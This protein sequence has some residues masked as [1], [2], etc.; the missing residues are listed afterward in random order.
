M[1][2]ILCT[3]SLALAFA[4][5]VLNQSAAAQTA[6]SRPHT[7]AA[8]APAAT[9]PAT[10][11]V[12][13]PAATPAPC[14]CMT[15]NAQRHLPPYTAKQET[16]HV[17]TLADGTNV[18]TVTEAEIWR[19]ADGRTRTDTIRT[20]PDGTITRYVSVYDPV[21]RVRYS[22]SVG[23]PS[24]SKIVSVYHY[25]QP[26]QQ[27]VPTIPPTARRYYPYKTESLPPQTINDIYVEGTRTTRTTP[28]GYEGNDRDI[29]VINE[30]WYSSE[31]GIQMRM[32]YDDPRNGKNTIEVTDIKRTAP[33]PALFKLPD[34]YTVH[35]TNPQ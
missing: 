28:A 1:R 5:A 27:S 20:Q 4:P 29:N 7:S 12:A 24:T 15:I 25:P 35:E 33:D 26:V 23:T 3:I 30:N 10:K 8:T 19:D 9:T 31:L 22:W 2:S 18:T 34:G 16:T 14:D 6:K 32:I 13:T 17:Q 11:S 21:T